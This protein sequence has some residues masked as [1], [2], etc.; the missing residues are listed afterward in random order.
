MKPALCPVE[1]PNLHAALAHAEIVR[2]KSEPLRQQV[3]QFLRD[4]AMP[5]VTF[6]QLALHDPFFVLDLRDGFAPR[7]GTRN[8]VLSFM[9]NY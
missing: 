6:G 9:E 7:D 2:A 3:E 5:A 1:F 8:R 4:H